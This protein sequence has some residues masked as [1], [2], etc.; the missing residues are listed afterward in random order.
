MPTSFTIPSTFTAVDKYSKVV[1]QMTNATSRFAQKAEANVSR[2]ERVFRRM[3]SP[4]QSINR[5]LGG[6]GLLLSGALIVSA[7]TGAVNIVKDFEQ[8]NAGL[9]AV[10]ADAT[11]PELQMMA[12]DAKRLGATTAKSATQVVGLQEA[13]ARLGFTTPEIINMT[14]ATIAGSIAMNGELDQTAELVGAM[15]RTFDSFSS[16]DAPDIIDQMT[17]STQKSALNFE[18]LQTALPIVAGA[19][20]A[21]GIPF[22]KLLALLGK[23]SDA[24]IDASSSSTALRNIFLTSASEG[25]N[26]DQ[27]LQKIVKNQDQLTAANDKFG[28]RAAVSGVILAKNLAATAELD[29]AIQSAGGSAEQ[30][31]NKQLNTLNGALTIL[32]SSYEGFILS[33]EDGTG[34]YAS[35]ATTIVQVVSEML[36]LASGSAV[37]SSELTE[38][39]LKIRSMAETG[40][41]LLQSFGYLIAA[42]ASFKALLIASRVVLAGYNIVLGISAALSST[43]SIAVGQNTIALGAYKVMMAIVTGVQWLWNAAISAGAVAMQILM[44]PITLIIL[45][46]AA[47]IA[48]ITLIVKKYHE[49]GAAVALLTGPLGFVINLIQSFRRNWDDIVKAFSTD[50]LL[51]GFKAIGATILDA[52]LMP[53]QQVFKLMSNIPGLGSFASDAVK[54]I[55][56]F[57]NK[58]G[59]NVSTDE[60]GKFINPTEPIVSPSDSTQPVVPA[61]NT[62]ALKQESL[63]QIIEEKRQNVAIDINDNTGKA[64]VKSDNQMVPV[65][66][67]TT[68]G[69]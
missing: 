52:V 32:Q 3:M 20:N 5:L 44:S 26:Y 37:A 42:I 54:N 40:M 64:K 25:L 38:T 36:S 43:A 15:V 45:G 18:K 10:M 53:L 19:A 57:R 60:S 8:A 61:I 69:F 22:T 55:E 13:F 48:Y 24:G 34:K 9:A 47:T 31:A 62:E 46:I 58:I 39:Q 35:T 21:A 49:W 51:A 65:N 4:L 33:L 59:V 11:G 14:Q 1:G 23:L 17:T 12:A 68:F 2:G 66:L 63:K 56:A 27:I 41:F 6:F 67:T 7:L 29:K 50:G 28:V 30:A 16:I